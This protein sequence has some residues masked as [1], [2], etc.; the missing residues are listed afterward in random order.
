MVLLSTIRSFFS[1]STTFMLVIILSLSGVVY[2]YKSSYEQK[3]AENAEIA[4]ARDSAISQLNTLSEEYEKQ[5]KKVNEYQ[6]R[7]RIIG[8]QNAKFQKEL[9]SYRKRILSAPKISAEEE[10]N[11]KTKTLLEGMRK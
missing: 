6:E 7:I 2:M 8:I 3:I 5:A 1:P 4:V 9:D 10:S 11:Q